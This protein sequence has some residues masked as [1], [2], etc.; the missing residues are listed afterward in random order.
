MATE[1]LN[2]DRCNAKLRPNAAYCEVCGQRT[3]RARRLTRTA[4][5]VE[6]LALVLVAVLIFVF[7][8]FYYTS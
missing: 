1:Q 7:A 2:C 4:V 3:R 6:L 5:R 8:Y